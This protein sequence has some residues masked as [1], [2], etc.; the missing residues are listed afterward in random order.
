MISP[1]RGFHSIVCCRI[2]LNLRRAASPG[3]GSTTV[4]T[5]S[6][7]FA[8]A[9]GQETNQVETLQLE[10]RGARSDDGDSHRQADVERGS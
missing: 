8:T 5:I 3:A 9:P 2:L 4:K 1:V 6:L 10:A 7:T